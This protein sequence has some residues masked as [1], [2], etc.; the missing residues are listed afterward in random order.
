VCAFAR[1]AALALQNTSG[2]EHQRHPVDRLQRA[3]IGATIR[4]GEP[5]PLGAMWDGQGTNFAVFSEVAERG[6]G[7]TA[8]MPNVT[9]NHR[10]QLTA[11]VLHASV[12]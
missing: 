6:T 12:D 9:S 10:T 2:H 7:S 11:N 8:P 4:P 3:P 5:F 1:C